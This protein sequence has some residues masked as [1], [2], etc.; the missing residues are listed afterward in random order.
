M[1]A[2]VPPALLGVYGV[3]LSTAQFG[4]VVTHQG[5]AKHVQRHWTSQVAVAPYTRMLGRA[6]ARP[7]LLMALGLGGFLLLLHFLSGVPAN[8]GLFLW[9]VVVNL[10]MVV[11][12]T[13]QA[14]LQAEDRFWA[15]F[16]ATVTSSATRS[17]L[18]P[19]LVT[20]FGATLF[21]LNT[22]FLL[23]AAATAGAAL[24][25]LH[26]AWRR[27][28]ATEG[29]E[30]DE[31]QLTI[32]AFA[33]VGICGWLAASAPRWFAAMTLT[34]VVTGYFV[35]AGNLTLIVPATVG[36]IALTYTFPALF[37]AARAGADGRTLLRMTNHAVAIVMLSSQLGIVLLRLAAPLL[38]GPIIAARYTGA[39]AWLLA[40]GGVSLAATTTQFYHNLLLAQNREPDCLRLSIL[41]AFFRLT[42]M[43]AGAAAGSRAFDLT[44]IGLPWLTVILEWWYV[45]RRLAAKPVVPAPPR[46]A[47]R[48]LVSDARASSQE[49]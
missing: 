26:A 31:L 2:V 9:M 42:A 23:H 13:A 19:L 36:T 12:Q 37:G 18:P 39:T 44:L 3:L 20:I 29:I 22:G 14:A 28:G 4:S 46:F 15:N 16:A 40:T 24:W 5:A 21:L 7:T 27:Q 6:S 17:F 1:S 48:E 49:R 43:T 32:R 8:I 34:P 25:F 33:G 30:E 47:S 41:S 38:I 45:R 35:L 11:T 10:L